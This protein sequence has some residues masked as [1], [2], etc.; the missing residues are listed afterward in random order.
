MIKHIYARESRLREPC[1]AAPH[2]RLLL[3]LLTLGLLVNAARAQE[4]TYLRFASNSLA[5]TTVDA[6][7]DSLTKGG[8]P[9][10]AGKGQDSSRRTGVDS[11]DPG[12]PRRWAGRFYEFRA[13]PAGERIVVLGADVRDVATWRSLPGMH[14]VIAD[15]G[16]VEPRGGLPDDPSLPE[17]WNFQRIEA[18]GAWNYTRGGV[19]ASGQRVVIGVIEV[20]GFARDHS[21]LVGQYFVNA[22]EIP[23]NDIDDDGN[24]LVDD[25]SGWNF[26]AMSGEFEPDSHGFHVSA[27][28][29]ARTDNGL[30]AAGLNADARLLPLTIGDSGVNWFAALDYLTAL[31]QEYNRTA[32]AAGAYVV[33]ANCSIGGVGDCTSDLWIEL[34]E[35]IE[36]AGTAG[37]LVVGAVSNDAGDLDASTDLPT[38]CT[39]DF[40]I[41]VT[42]TTRADS[43]RGNTGFS[44]S[45]VDLGAP[46]D[47]FRSGEYVLFGRVT[48]VFSGTS[49]ATPHVAGAVALLYSADCGALES[50]SLSDPAATALEIKSYILDNVDAVA[51]L[52]PRTLSGGRLNIRRAMEALVGSGSCS[53]DY[54][55]VRFGD[56]ARV[57]SRIPVENGPALTLLDTLS[58]AW[59]IYRYAVGTWRREVDVAIAR[60]DGVTAW[61]YDFPLLATSMRFDLDTL[62]DRP[63]ELAI[64]PALPRADEV[65]AGARPTPS[66]VA[67]F[68][69]AALMP[70][71][72]FDDDLLL[73]PADVPDNGLDDDGNG[74]VDDAVA[75]DLARDRSIGPRGFGVQAEASLLLTSGLC[76]GGGR[77]RYQVPTLQLRGSTYGDWLKGASAVHQLASRYYANAA[78]AAAA[79]VVYAAAV[80]GTPPVRPA[81]IGP[82]GSL[83]AFAVSR[84]LDAGVV[85]V[86]PEG[87]P[88][89]SGSLAERAVGSIIASAA[90][91]T[92]AGLSPFVVR[93][94]SAAGLACEG[95]SAIESFRGEAVG[96]ADVASLAALFGSVDC[97]AVTTLAAAADRAS[98]V[99]S[100]LTTDVMPLGTTAPAA[101]GAALSAEAYYAVCRAA[102]ADSPC[103]FVSFG[104]NPL[105]HGSRGSA[106]LIAAAG[107]TCPLRVVDA[108][109]RTLTTVS[110]VGLGTLTRLSLPT[111]TLPAGVY[112][113]QFGDDDGASAVPIVVVAP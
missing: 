83:A 17:Q 55:L 105:R 101:F 47:S 88:G 42:A 109:G 61:E 113:L 46:G 58:S 93:T 70:G 71:S 45:Q 6:I 3:V 100:A 96:V 38:S 72:A 64:A 18:L 68:D 21:E 104:P 49:G 69:L 62:V 8:E 29:G 81:G 73:N 14:T 32:G 9:Q 53:P 24:G 76:T 56:A 22:A 111:A 5:A 11:R 1:C 12:Q 112:Y 13:A 25:V 97:S 35:A 20:S 91:S 89:P 60:L 107:A 54:A 40:L 110:V 95:S 66:A 75:I 59:Q 98:R 50:R 41:S 28:L 4:T 51:Q 99:R 108:L 44:A 34:N 84:L 30:Q 43:L 19:T 7:L 23:D 80:R 74:F 106:N 39:S 36:R 79:P 10:S 15:A 37:I 26:D 67:R 33:V 82:D 16:E 77:G 87:D 92:P 90:E 85:T 65:L 52:R 103:E 86:L 94:R 63:S 2:A 31:R 27:I 48:D 78:S 57:P 102:S